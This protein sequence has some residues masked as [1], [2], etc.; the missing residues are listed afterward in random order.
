MPASDVPFIQAFRNDRAAY[1]RRSMPARRAV[2]R[3]ART[4]RPLAFPSDRGH[5]VVHL[6]PYHLRDGKPYRWR[7]THLDAQGEPSGHCEAEDF[8]DALMSAR[9]FG[10]DLTRPMEMEAFRL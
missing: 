8:R 4:P 3:L 5:E 6:D 1:L 9:T 2:R 10:A 7:V